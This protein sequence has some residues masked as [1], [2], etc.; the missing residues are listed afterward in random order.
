MTREEA[1]KKL[2]TA[3]RLSVA[4]AE[5]LYDSIIPKPVVPQYVADWYEEHKDEFYL[6]LHRVVRDFFEHFNDYYFSENP[7]DYDFACWYYNTK[8]AIQILVNMHQFG[9]EVEGEKKYTVRIRNL[10]DEETYLNYDNFRETWVFYS[11]EDTDR[12]RTTHTKKQLE[13]GCFGWVFDCDGVEVKEV[14][15]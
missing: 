9:Y 3:G 15:E 7:I 13:D 6:N 10:D 2:V 5:D 1:V 14:T 4:H 11:R 8:N 12:F